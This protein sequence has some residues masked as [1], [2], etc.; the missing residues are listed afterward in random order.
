M[1]QQQ[2]LAQPQFTPQQLAELQKQNLSPIQPAPTNS[3]SKP[4]TSVSKQ[5]PNLSPYNASK[6]PTMSQADAFNQRD[7]IG[8]QLSSLETQAQMTRANAS[9]MPA[10]RKGGVVKKKPVAAAKKTTTAKYAK[11]GMVMSNCGASM[12]PQQKRKK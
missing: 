10:M 6:Q 12:K 7:A 9:K 8:Q 1:Q 11:G 5:S 4:A 3:P 2:A